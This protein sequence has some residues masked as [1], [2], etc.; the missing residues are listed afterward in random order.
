MN[1]YY[2]LPTIGRA[3]DAMDDCLNIATILQRMINMGAKVTVN[4]LLTC[5]ASVSFDQ[6]W[7]SSYS[8]FIIF[9]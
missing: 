6:C 9:N 7:R 1:E 2:D 5:C 8:L 4:E 3:H